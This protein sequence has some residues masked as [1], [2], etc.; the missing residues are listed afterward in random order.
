MAAATAPIK[1]DTETDQFDGTTK[2]TVSLVTGMTADEL[3][4]LG[5]F[6]QQQATAAEE[7]HAHLSA[8]LESMPSCPIVFAPRSERWMGWGLT[9]QH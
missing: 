5:G 7:E 8:P 2:R 9:S 3:D 6:E 1:I 4:D